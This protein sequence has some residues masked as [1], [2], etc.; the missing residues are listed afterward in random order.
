MREILEEI[1]FFKVKSS[2]WVPNLRGVSPVGRDEGCC[3]Y[4]TQAVGRSGTELGDVEEGR[5]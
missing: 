3:S 4:V 2:G 5:R 1:K